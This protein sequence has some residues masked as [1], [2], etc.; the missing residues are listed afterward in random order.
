MSYNSLANLPSLH[1]LRLLT[2]PTD[3]EPKKTLI[4]IQFMLS[5]ARRVRQSLTSQ[6]RTKPSGRLTKAVGAPGQEG[7]RRIEAFLCQ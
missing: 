4:R 6:Y 2:K 1:G 7:E 5:V 3:E